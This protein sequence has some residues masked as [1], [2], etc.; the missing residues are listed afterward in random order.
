MT[1]KTLSFDELLAAMP[2]LA[3]PDQMQRHMTDMSGFE[4][5][6]PSVVFRPVST[7]QVA[8]IVKTCAAEDRK[9]TIQG[10]LTGLAGG[11]RPNEGD[12]VIALENMKQIEEIDTV[13]GVAIVQAGV[14]L[15]NLC[16]AVEQ[17]GWYFPLDFGSRG[18]CVIG[19]NVS[20]NAGGN[21]VLR[22]GTTRD[23]VLGMEVVL[24]D[25]TV[26][27][28]LNRVIKNNTGLDLKHLFIGTEGRLG[29]ITRLSL[30]L[31]PNP[32]TRATALV[33]LDSFDSVTRMLKQ[34]RSDLP[35]LSS[36]EV[37]WQS[38]LQQAAVHAGKDVP[39]EGRYP[40]YVLVEIEGADK[41]VFHEGFSAFLE[42]L[43]ESGIGSDVIIPQ[44]L[45]QANSLW[46]I[47]DAIGEILGSIKPY[48]A[49]DIS[50]PL[51]HMPE[52]IQQ[53]TAALEE[54]YPHSI[55]L[56]FGHLGDGNLHL[57][58]GKHKEEDILAV[59]ELVY[60]IASRFRGSISA[61]HGI[62]RIK[63]PFLHYS[64]SEDEIKL[65]SAIKNLIN[66]QDLFNAG[67]LVD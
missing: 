23:L 37:M 8:A 5:A 6:M 16:T 43:L 27:N 45:E 7:D 66:P 62:G 24:P 61:E 21:K 53:S 39:F 58:T 54:K 36:F 49:F 57:T 42:S 22:Y 15:E 59:E 18:S 40:I 11:A 41:P 44:T 47:R 35:D 20:T 26:L 31:F 51:K 63:K 55:N 64:R 13:G 9:I 4:A 56:L 67:R 30:R 17:E 12:V 65:M 32:Q 25:G 29:I 3:S 48:V 2:N 1:D 50:I 14:I 28:M 10:G 60:M 33:A 46:Q 38:Y 34:A 19:G 52:F